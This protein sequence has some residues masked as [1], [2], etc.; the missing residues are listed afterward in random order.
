MPGFTR[1]HHIHDYREFPE[2]GQSDN[3]YFRENRHNHVKVSIDFVIFRQ[4]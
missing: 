4:K 2:N 1:I 3:G